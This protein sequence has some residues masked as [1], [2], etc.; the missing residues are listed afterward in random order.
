MIYMGLPKQLAQQE[1]NAVPYS[2]A[3]E[4]AGSVWEAATGQPARGL[5]V[6]K[7]PSPDGVGLSEADRER[8]RGWW[9]GLEPEGKHGVV[10]GWKESMMDGGLKEVKDSKDLQKGEKRKKEQQGSRAG[11]RSRTSTTAAAAAAVAEGSAGAAA[12]D[13]GAT[14]R[15]VGES[16]SQQ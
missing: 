14:G 1:G 7:G 2:V 4:V 11:K 16:A 5:P 12:A 3:V 10:L 13:S 9:E 8:W 6:L 15:S